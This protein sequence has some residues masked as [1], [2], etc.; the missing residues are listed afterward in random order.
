MC[1]RDR[2]RDLAPPVE[3]DGAPDVPAPDGN[4]VG[5][6]NERAQ[7]GVIADLAYA[8]DATGPAHRPVFT[9]T[10]SCVHAADSYAYSAEATSKNEAKAAA[11][12][13]L[14]DQ[15]LSAERTHLAGLAR[16]RRE[17]ARTPEGIFTRLL[18]AGCPVNFTGCG[19]RIG[20]HLPE[21]LVGCELPVLSA[22]PVLVTLEGPVHPSTRTWACGAR[23]ALEAVAARHVYPALDAD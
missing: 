8:H 20:G 6:R 3:G 17:Q 16:T 13:G 1:I 22:L 10:A 11:A 15:V 2:V 12:A 21:P 5:L 9:C 23:V 4:P 19:F 18:R 7:V 14:L